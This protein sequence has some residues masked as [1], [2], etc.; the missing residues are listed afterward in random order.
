MEDMSMEFID[1]EYH[2]S[3]I[4]VTPYDAPPNSRMYEKGDIEEMVT[5]KHGYKKKPLGGLRFEH[6]ERTIT[7]LGGIF[8]VYLFIKEMK[9]AK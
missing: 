6:I 4:P 9:N 7:V 5:T 3:N 8:L 1:R 2:H